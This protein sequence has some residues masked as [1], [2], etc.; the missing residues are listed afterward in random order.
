MIDLDCSEIKDIVESVS[1]DEIR[2]ELEIDFK[3]SKNNKRVKASFDPIK[4]DRSVRRLEDE[5]LKEM[6]SMSS[7]F[8]R[9]ENLIINNLNNLVSFLFIKKDEN[10]HKKIR[11]IRKYEKNGRLFES[12]MIGN[13]PKFVTIT[14]EGHHLIEEIEEGDYVFC[15]TDNVITQNPIPYSFDSQEE[16]EKYI[17]LARDEDFDS[18]FIK[19]FEKFKLYLNSE[20]HT[21]VIL[22]G[23]TIYS[24]FQNKFGTTHYNIFVGEGG[25]GKNSALLVLKMLGYRPFYVTSANAANYYTFLGDIQEGQGI[26]LEDEADNIGNSSDKKNVLKTGYASGGCVPKI[27]FSKDGNRYQESFLTFCFKCYAMEELPGDKN[28]RGIFD[29]SFIHHFFKGDTPYNI[30]NIINE[31]ESNL[32][33]DL[34]H[35]RKLLLVFK[36]LNYNRRFPEIKTNLTARDAELT[37]PLLQIFYTRKNFEKIRIALSKM[38]YE[39]TS[40]KG[41]SI[42]AKITET[43]IILGN[44]DNNKNRQI[45][46]FTNE[47]FENVFKEIAET[48]VNS[49]DTIGS[50]FYLPD[51]TRIS[52]YKIS[53]LLRSK[54]NAKPHRTNKIRGYSVIRSDVK[55]VSKQYEV[56][57]DILIYNH[58]NRF[59]KVTEVTE[60]TEFRDVSTSSGMPSDIGNSENRDE[61]KSNL[62]IQKRNTRLDKNTSES[63]QDVDGN[64]SNKYETITE[65]FQAH[66]NPKSNP[67]TT[68]PSNSVTSVTNVIATPPQFPCYFCGN[69]YTTNIDFDMGN[70]FLEKHIDQLYDIPISGNREKKIEWIIAETKHRLL[71]NNS[72]DDNEEKEDEA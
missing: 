43:L 60:V 61:C 9:I 18:L 10:K 5:L 26:I 36:L 16:L 72:M 39:K 44:N 24:Y 54:F 49:F 15:P 11:Y 14:N 25:S 20:E 52:K 30:K 3:S 19:I 53:N 2:K 13:L 70:H 37:H 29:R 62:H 27:G 55:K 12:V 4:F 71:E 6:P 51:G 35:L 31:K 57:E 63:I 17:N 48:K 56:I 23:D 64:R 21:L 66:E 59:P 32:H 41:N 7:E 34:I 33:K 46:E 28:N 8:K 22:A 50:T 65:N 67:Y 38:I 69:N 58:E 68:I 45:I 42:E 40:K 47:E 1:F